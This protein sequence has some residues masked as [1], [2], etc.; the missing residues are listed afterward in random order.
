MIGDKLFTKD[1][2]CKLFPK[3][4]GKFTD[5]LFGVNLHT[6]LQCR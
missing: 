1:K 2:K 4:C 3:I 5:L 6:V